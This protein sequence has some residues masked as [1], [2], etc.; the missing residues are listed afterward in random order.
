MSDEERRVVIERWYDEAWGRGNLDVFDELYTP[1]WI[2]HF[3]QGLE[4][5]GP[6]AHK[7]FGQ[8]FGAAFP[9]GRYTV[10]ETLVAGDRVV[11]RYT[12]RGTHQG[13]LRGI[14]PTGRP[15][16][17]IG[18]TI[19][20]LVG[21]HIAEQWAEYDMLGLLQQLGVIPPAG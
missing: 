4:L 3:P 6:A 15:V 11:T 12:F 10:E 1:D 17:L 20:R 9:D 2:G 7:Q 21:G 18:I 8:V 14:A 13:A 16:A 19:Q 5:R